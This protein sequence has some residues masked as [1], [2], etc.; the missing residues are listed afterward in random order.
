M[1]KDQKDIEKLK[2]RLGLTSTTSSDKKE[3]LGLPQVSRK[4]VGLGRSIDSDKKKAEESSGLIDILSLA[5]SVEKPSQSWD[6]PSLREPLLLNIGESYSPPV[7]TMVR[8]LELGRTEWQRWV[9]G[10]TVIRYFTDS[11]EDKRILMD[12][13][14]A[15][16]EF[17]YRAY[18]WGQMLGGA[19]ALY[20]TIVDKLF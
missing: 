4:V 19:A 9:P 13:H 15:L 6:K 8:T 10:T 18:A 5:R 17:G 7:D 20:L 1:A 14:S 3:Q 11:T 12:N 2:A 16:Y